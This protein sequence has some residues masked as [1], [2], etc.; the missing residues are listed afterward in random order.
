MSGQQQSLCGR[1]KSLTEQLAALFTHDSP[2]LGTKMEAICGVEMNRMTSAATPNNVSRLFL[3]FI[4]FIVP[5][6]GTKSHVGVQESQHCFGLSLCL[7]VQ[8]TQHVVNIHRNHPTFS[9][10][11]FLFQLNRYQNVQNHQERINTTIV[12]AKT[13]IMKKNPMRDNRKSM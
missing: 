4:V 1:R 6:S 7:N 12:S 9:E 13:I 3:G 11:V 10:L 5:H 8:N 2:A